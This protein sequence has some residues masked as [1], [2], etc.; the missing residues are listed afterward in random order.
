MFNPHKKLW[1]RDIELGEI[2]KLLKKFREDAQ[3]ETEQMKE[4]QARTEEKLSKAKTEKE[5]SEA[6]KILF[7]IVEYLKEL[8][9]FNADAEELERQ[10]K[11]C[12]A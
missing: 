10:F 11:I 3:L 2:E 7:R 1:K 9:L 4:S 12:F 6:N 8:Q 5:V